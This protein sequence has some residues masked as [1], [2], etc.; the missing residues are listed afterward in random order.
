MPHSGHRE[1]LKKKNRIGCLEDHELVELLLFYAIPR[2]NTNEIA[3]ALMSRFGSIRGILDAETTAL[4]AVDGIEPQAAEFLKTLGDVVGRYLRSDIDTK[5][6]CS[7]KENMQKY[8]TSWFMGGT[9]DPLRKTRRREQLFYAALGPARASSCDG[10][11][12]KLRG[13]GAQSSGG[14]VDT[15][16]GGCGSDQTDAGDIGCGRNPIPGA[17]HHIGRRVCCDI[18]SRARDVFLM[19]Y[20]KQAAEER[21]YVP[22]LFFDAWRRF[23]IFHRS[24]AYRPAC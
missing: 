12:R 17:L 13:A 4:C 8:L 6:L 11:Q 14:D 1:R 16:Q 3:H 24:P 7:S 23:S 21:L 2:V 10:G 5:T 15:L 20:K 19:T 22:L 18:K 9:T